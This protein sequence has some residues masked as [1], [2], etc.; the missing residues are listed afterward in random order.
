MMNAAAPRHVLRETLNANDEL[1]TISQSSG[2]ASTLDDPGPDLVTIR[3]R[4]WPPSATR[5]I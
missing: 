5:P 1:L 3:E 2:I 4:Q